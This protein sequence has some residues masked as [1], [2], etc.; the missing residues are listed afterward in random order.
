MI[1]F[2]DFTKENLEKQS[3]AEL[4]DTANVLEDE[5]LLEA[6]Q[7]RMSNTKE[8]MIAFLLAAVAPPEAKP[9]FLAEPA[10]TETPPSAEASPE[11]APEDTAEHAM[12]QAEPVKDTVSTNLGVQSK[13]PSVEQTL[14]DQVQ[15]PQKPDPI[16][17]SSSSARGRLRTKTTKA[18]RTGG[19]LTIRAED[20]FKQVTTKE[21][22]I[23]ADIKQSAT[24]DVRKILH[25]TVNAIGEIYAGSQRRFYAKL[26]YG[27]YQVLIKDENFVHLTPEM[28]ENPQEI[29]KLMDNRTESE[30]D[31]V[32]I[33]EEKEGSPLV[34]G[35]R[36]LA[37]EKQKEI[38]WFSPSTSGG[39]RLEEGTIA[40]ARVVSVVQSGIWIELGGVETM[41]PL[42]EL[43]YTP[44]KD[45]RK[46]IKDEKEIDVMIKS[47]SRNLKTKEVEFTAS[48][49]DT[50]E[51]T[52][53]MTYDMIRKGELWTGEVTRLFLTVAPGKRPGVIVTLSCGYDCY[54]HF[55]D[56]LPEIGD[57]VRV[58][59]DEKFD[60]DLRIKGTIWHIK[61]S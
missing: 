56:V 57:T 20:K 52:R 45:A 48:Y 37:M 32:I 34:E 39:W 59:I 61:R 51:D 58:H 3:K 25:G 60:Q 10:A 7:I 17:G 23:V 21:E 16:I 36:L 5:G 13:A 18:Y 49:K 54:C 41:I 29:K 42:K 9:A 4:L 15:N 35:S 2:D 8:Q 27:H 14:L 47:I 46:F 1:N 55:K 53:F 40:Q 28:R 11:H 43:D 31:F 30:I 22:T 44:P 6:D 24:K 26:V 19:R 12:F 38:W 50:K 33:N